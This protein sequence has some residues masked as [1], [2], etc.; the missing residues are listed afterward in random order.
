MLILPYRM[1]RLNRSIRMVLPKA[2]KLILRSKEMPRRLW[3]QH[4]TNFSAN[5]RWKRQGSEFYGVYGYTSFNAVRYFEDIPRQ[6]H[7]DAEK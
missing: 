7:Y 1:E 5:S 4:L 3:Q 2:R 6:G